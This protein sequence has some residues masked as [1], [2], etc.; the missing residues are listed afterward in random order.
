MIHTTTKFKKLTLARFF[1]TE[2]DENVQCA[3]MLIGRKARYM[4]YLLKYRAYTW[5]AKNYLTYRAV[6]RAGDEVT[7]AADKTDKR[8]EC[9]CRFDL[10][11]H[12]YARG[13]QKARVIKS[14]LRRFIICHCIN[15]S[16]TRAPGCSGISNVRSIFFIMF[17]TIFV[18]CRCFRNKIIKFRW[19][20]FARSIYIKKTSK[21]I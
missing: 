17:L 19:N 4:L 1:S 9:S 5:R 7:C 13:M 8:A 11:W 6:F 10:R 2:N 14:S 18:L 12:F 20:I 16:L 3:C 21:S 15:P